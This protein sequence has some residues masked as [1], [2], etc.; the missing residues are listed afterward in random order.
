MPAPFI[1]HL[2]AGPTTRTL[3][4]FKAIEITFGRDQPLPPQTSARQAP[5]H[6]LR[7]HLRSPS[8]PQ[9]LERRVRQLPVPP[10]PRRANSD[11]Y[12]AR[13]KTHQRQPEHTSTPRHSQ[14]G[15]LTDRQRFS[16]G[17]SGPSPTQRSSPVQMGLRDSPNSISATDPHLVKRPIEEREGTCLM[18]DTCH[19]NSCGLMN[20]KTCSVQSPKSAG[21]SYI[22]SQIIPLTRLHSP[23]VRSPIDQGTPFHAPHSSSPLQPLSLSLRPIALATDPLLLGCC[24]G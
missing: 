4:R 11:A 3:L 20:R 8:D 6:R 14:T 15:P 2:R 13:W 12:A 10:I 5:Q 18:G 7:Q 22:R 23:T 16:C 24:S 1:P 19:V 21:R 9:G 17:K